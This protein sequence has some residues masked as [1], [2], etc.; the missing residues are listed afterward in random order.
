MI[1]GRLVLIKSVITT[2][3][4]HHLPVTD[5]PIWLL[6][7]IDKCRCSFFWTGKKAANGGQ[8]LVAWGENF[9]PQELGGLGF[10]NMQ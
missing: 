7:E 5:V 6:E 8:C 2:R 10:K 4:I 9:M 3:T 1:A